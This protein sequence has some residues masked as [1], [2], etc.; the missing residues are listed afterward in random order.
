M[1]TLWI[2]LAIQIVLAT[3]VTVLMLGTI[4]PIGMKLGK[5]GLAVGP[6]FLTATILST[7][8]T[9]ARLVAQKGITQ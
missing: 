7:R 2:L 8:K 4:D 6:L 1:R 5:I 3:V 9:N